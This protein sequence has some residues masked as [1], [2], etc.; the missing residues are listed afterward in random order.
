MGA[1]AA[2]AREAVATAEVA[3]AGA[4]VEVATAEAA[5]EVVETAAGVTEVAEW[6]GVLRTH[7]ILGPILVELERIFDLEMIR[8]GR[9]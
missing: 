5:M 4:K 6:G 2:E 1:R 9:S 3:T 7:K 8:Y